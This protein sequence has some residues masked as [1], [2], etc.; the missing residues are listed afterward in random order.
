MRCPSP[1]TA[2]S[3]AALVIAL[4]GTSYAAT[5]GTFLLGRANKASALSSLSNSKGTALRLSSKQGTPPLTVSNS[6]LVPSLNASELGGIPAAGFMQGTGSTDSGSVA[7]TGPG[8]GEIIAGPGSSITGICDADSTAGADLVVDLSVAGT[9]VWWNKDGT[10][11]SGSDSAQITPESQLDYVVIVQVVQG[12]AVSTY[13]A[14]QTYS[15]GQCTFAA[16]LV[17]TN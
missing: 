8:S 10:S 1:A 9:I 15:A 14:T 12:A 17:A 13:T 4:S 16:Q 11:N 3:V 5:G 6:V 7:I 2:I